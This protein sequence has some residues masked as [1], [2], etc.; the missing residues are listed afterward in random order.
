[1]RKS[2]DE[3][4]IN[5]YSS[6]LFKKEYLFYAHIIAKCSIKIDN[7]LS[8]PAGV[9]FVNSSWQLYVNE[10]IMSEYSLEHRIGIL[11]HECLHIIMGHINRGELIDGSHEDKNIS[12]DCA[13]NQL[14]NNDHLP[15]ITEKDIEKYGAMNPDMKLGD[16]VAIFPHN[17]PVKKDTVVPEMLSFEEYYEILINNKDSNDYED[18]N[19]SDSNDSDSSDSNDSNSSDS[20]DSNSSSSNSSDE[21]SNSSDSNDSNS[22]KPSIDTHETWKDSKGDEQLQNDMTRE[23]IE[24][25]IT[26]T[27]K[28]RGNLP[29][30]I[31][32]MLDLFTNKH[33]IDWK[34]VLRRIVGKK[35][36]G[37]QRTIMRPNR[38]QPDNPIIKGKKKKKTFTIVVGVD[39]SGSM[40]NEEILK[41]LN[42]ISYICKSNNTKMNIIQIDTEV[43][44]IQEFTKNTKLFERTGNGGTIMNVCPAYITENKIECDALVMISDMYIEEVNEDP[45]W[46]KFRKKVIWLSTSDYIPKWNGWNKHQILNL[47]GE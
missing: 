15:K 45:I 42:E 35:K 12:M 19:S 18:S 20:N 28:Q 16:D 8:A 14:I 29:S 25:A 3:A 47:K 9:S 46:G 41:G 40:S 4:L 13:I 24:S 26:E 17:F 22:S 10:N 39:I 37:Y 43:H 36:I 21:E 6:D 32:D 7:N 38:R 1:M 30:N 11:K 33:V 44:K 34:T 2:L 5:M 23:M 31:S 27:Q